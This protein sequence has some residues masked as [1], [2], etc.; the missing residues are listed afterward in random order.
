M[1]ERKKVFLRQK[2]K[3]KIDLSL[4]VAAM[5]DFSNFETF[6]DMFQPPADLDS[7]PLNALIN[8]V[9]YNHS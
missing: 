3:L 5:L 2:D 7:A 4:V 1:F 9:D 6:W 8:V